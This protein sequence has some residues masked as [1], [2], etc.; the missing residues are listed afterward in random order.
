[1]RV[2]QP[3]ALLASSRRRPILLA[4]AVMAVGL[5]AALLVGVW[6]EAP[7]VAGSLAV[8]GAVALGIGAAQLYRALDPRGARMR[9]RRLAELLVGVFGDDYALVVAPRLPV[10][11]SAR[12]DG[13]L[14]GP[15][16]IRVIT[17]RDWEGRYRV[18]GKVWEFDARGRHGW[19]RCRTNPSHDAVAL[20]DG[21][22]RWAARAGLGD[23]P[24]RATVA[25]PS[26]RSRIVLEEPADEVVTVENAPWWANSIGRARRLDP[27]AAAR[28]LSTILDAGEGDAAPAARRPAGDTA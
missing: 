25:F 18:R 12:L 9:A 26:P 22:A 20:A 19:I 15:A 24:V 8:V 23:L 1:M 28:V 17:A 4:L 2:I 11:D 10:R 21:V 27:E 14:V 7:M 13:I 16:G 6:G 5:L 3:A